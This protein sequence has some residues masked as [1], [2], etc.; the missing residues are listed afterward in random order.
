MT[1]PSAEARLGATIVVARDRSPSNNCAFILQSAN[2][3]CGGGDRRVF[4]SR[5]DGRTRVPW[6]LLLLLIGR[7]PP[8]H[9]HLGRRCQRSL[10]CGHNIQW[11]SRTD[12]AHQNT[13]NGPQSDELSKCGRTLSG[14]KTT[15]VVLEMM[16]V[17]CRA[18]ERASKIRLAN[19]VYRGAFVFFLSYLV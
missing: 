12:R 5:I 17:E 14:T 19:Q 11:N 2:N 6:L 3:Q 10:N 4:E 18:V 7:W 15:L 8:G 16:I 1:R 9:I 13:Q